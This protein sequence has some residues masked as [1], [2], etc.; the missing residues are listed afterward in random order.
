MTST[1]YYH[2]LNGLLDRWESLAADL[3][4]VKRLRRLRT[5]DG[6][7]EAPLGWR[8]SDLARWPL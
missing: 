1:P 2:V 3:L 6:P 4:S 5:P 7:N 8:G